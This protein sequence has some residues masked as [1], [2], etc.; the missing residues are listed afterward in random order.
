MGIRNK[1][2]LSLPFWF[3]LIGSAPPAVAAEE[4]AS[5]VVATRHVPPF[6]IRTDQ[7][8]DGIAVEL[9]TRVAASLGYNYVFREMGLSEMLEVVASGNADAAV[10]ALTI[11]SEREGRVDFTHPF[12]TSGLG[13]A[14]HQRPGGGWV[15]S[16]KQVFSGPFLKVLAS[17]L[18][19]LTLVGVLVWLAERHRNPQF[20]RRP[21]HGIA[22]GLWWSA[23]TMT[24]V[25]YGDKAPVTLA[26]RLVAM[27]WMFASVIIISSF[28]AA[29][30]TALT[31]GTLDQG[32]TGIE[33]LYRSR[34][35]TLPGSTSEAFLEQRLVRYRTASDL[36]EALN[37]L[38]AREADAVV[39]DAPVL[40]YLVAE[41]HSDSLRVLPHVL[42]RQ[43][44]GIALPAGSPL[45]EAINRALLVVIRSAEWQRLL[46]GY[47]GHES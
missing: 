6:A 41:R 15:A 5:L 27:V 21:V 31:V 22:S 38:A 40:R 9:W 10:A 4:P 43:D 12:H 47:L 32:I 39:Y 24:T 14:V 18:A 17:L 1:L 33:D 26:G 42:Q 16:L 8:W 34:V 29:I 13:I 30:A 44:Y 37:A 46:E 28:T 7:G 23:V 20:G 36:T 25:G 3:F 11:T 2:H 19:L 35:V 45:R